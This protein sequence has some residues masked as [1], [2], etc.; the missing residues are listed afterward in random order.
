MLKYI[1]GAAVL[2]VAAIGGYFLVTKYQSPEAN[3]PMPEESNV[4]SVEVVPIEH[5]TGILKWDGTDIYFDPV[6][7]KETFANQPP[8][9]LVLVTDIHGDHLSTT[10]IAAILGSAPLIVPQAVKDLLP[11]DLQAKVAVLA[12][13]Q[14]YTDT[15]GF[16]I[17]AIPM[18]NLPTAEN[19]DR[20]VKGRGN[21]Y[22]IEKEG[23]RVY[24]AGDTAGTLEM[25][26]MSDIDVAFVPM[27]MPYTMSVEE[28]A[29]AVLSFRPRTVYPYHYRTPEGLA[30]VDKFKQL[31]NAGDP[32]ITVILGAWYPTE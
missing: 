7:G 19:K 30:D 31:V 29:D 27:N 20:H 4:P 12:N 26:S 25:R 10:T 16:L 32:N 15:N 9:D 8:A 5:A 13:G 1:V 14:S 28:A 24:I 17:T 3:E 18:Y 2:V 22:L 21:G 23:F 11:A 6:G